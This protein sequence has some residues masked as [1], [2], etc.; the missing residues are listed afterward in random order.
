MVVYGV[1][2]TAHEEITNNQV[3]R[4]DFLYTTEENA[5]KHAEC[6]P[7]FDRYGFEVSVRVVEITIL[8]EVPQRILDL[9]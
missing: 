3:W 1:I 2:T 6:V 7:S 8:E 4:E 5:R 9:E